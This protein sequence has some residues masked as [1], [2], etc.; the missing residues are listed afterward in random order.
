MIA[1]ADT[2]PLN[3]LILID[4][5]R[6]LP[7]LFERVLIPPAVFEELRNPKAPEL[8]R[9]W[10]TDPPS[11]LEVQRVRPRPGSSL[12]Y[13]DAGEPEAIA[14]A[15]ELQADYVLLDESEARQEAAHRKL[16]Y[17]GTLGILRQAAQLGL[18]DLPSTLTRLQQT[19]FQ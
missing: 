13:L 17:I 1:V 5:T 3:Y 7:A 15:E 12:D 19:T 16:P 18:I 10:L 11:W 8:V 14:L 6:L 4:Q 9:S 2:T